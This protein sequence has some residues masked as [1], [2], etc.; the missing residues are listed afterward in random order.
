MKKIV[1]VLMTITASYLSNE[2]INPP[3]KPVTNKTV[4]LAILK[5]DS[6]VNLKLGNPLGRLSWK[7]I[8][9]PC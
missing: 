8:S 1:F 6:V 4:P 5:T 9:A 2:Q 3:Q 7:G